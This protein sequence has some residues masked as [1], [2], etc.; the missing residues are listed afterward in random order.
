VAIVNTTD[1]PTTDNP[2]APILARMVKMWPPTTE[3]VL[4]HGS[5]RQVV[6]FPGQQVVLLDEGYTAARVRDPRTYQEVSVPYEFIQIP[7]GSLPWIEVASHWV[8]AIRFYRKRVFKLL[9]EN[10]LHVR[11]LDGAIAEY[12]GVS[13]DEWDDFVR[14]GRDASYGGW[15]WD[16]VV[17][18]M[19]YNLLRGKTGRPKPPRRYDAVLRRDR[20]KVTVNQKGPGRW[21]AQRR[22]G[23]GQ[24]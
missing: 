16:N 10:A 6:L 8:D 21:T 15:L 7:L 24:V 3:G 1:G 13:E 5:H 18:K 12:P 20:G 19:P 23:G 22:G 2:D 4:Q 9:P 17:K 11:F 14:G